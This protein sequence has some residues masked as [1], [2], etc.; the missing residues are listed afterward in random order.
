MPLRSTRTLRQVT[1][2]KILAGVDPHT[3]LAK[4]L[5]AA[6]LTRT[7]SKQQLNK[8]N[9][10]NEEKL[11]NLVSLSLHD[12]D[13]VADNASHFF[14]I[15]TRLELK[16]RL[17]ALQ[18]QLNGLLVATKLAWMKCFA[19]GSEPHLVAPSP[20]RRHSSTTCATPK[21]ALVAATDI[22]TKGETLAM[23]L[24]LAFAK[25]VSTS[26]CPIK[27][28]ENLVAR[29]ET[30]FQEFQTLV[31]DVAHRSFATA[32]HILPIEST[33]EPVA[34][35]DKI[36]AIEKHHAAMSFDLP[37]MKRYCAKVAPP[38]SSYLNNKK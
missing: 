31:R 32:Q 22:V 25:A 8:Q 12:N 13:E 30:E 7:A 34:S 6:R 28:Y 18:Q 17:V 20:Q 26:N 36:K 35:P 23:N 11:N 27:E 2:T 24:Q 19:S 38:Y 15:E 1:K 33:E 16:E 4:K 10:D 3:S 37:S 14:S 9:N 29:V 21:A 5:S